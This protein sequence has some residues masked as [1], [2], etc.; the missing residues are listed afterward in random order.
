[1][2]G[3]RKR[4]CLTAVNQLVLGVDAEHNLAA[5]AGHVSVRDVAEVAGDQGEEVG[6]LREG[7]DPL[8]EVPAVR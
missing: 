4:L 6:R 2:R 8:G 7:V 3:R 1:M 5:G